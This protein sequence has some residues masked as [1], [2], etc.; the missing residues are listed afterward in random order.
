MDPGG[1]CRADDRADRLLRAAA[2]ANCAA[3]RSVG[4]KTRPVAGVAW[5]RDRWQDVRA[6][7]PTAGRRPKPSW[8]RGRGGEGPVATQVP[9]VASGE[10]IA[11]I[12]IR[13]RSSARARKSTAI[14]RRTVDWPGQRGRLTCCCGPRGARPCVRL[15]HRWRDRPRAVASALAHTARLSRASFGPEMDVR[16]VRASVTSGRFLSDSVGPV[17]DSHGSY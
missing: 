2:R 1:R 9:P 4:G 16:L 3:R 17:T 7:P 13:G 12:R 10:F 14:H 5:R 8:H 6:E 11:R 15:F